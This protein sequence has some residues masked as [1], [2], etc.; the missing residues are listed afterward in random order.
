[1]KSISKWLVPGFLR[2]LD[3]YLR[4]RYPVIWY[5]GAHWVLFYGLTG[6]ILLFGAGMLY[7]VHW[8]K[9]ELVKRKIHE[10]GSLGGRSDSAH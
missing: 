7:P 8:V 6:E 4:E 5:S 3:K 1:M 9:R 2:R 10:S